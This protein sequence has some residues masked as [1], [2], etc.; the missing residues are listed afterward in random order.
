MSLITSSRPSTDSTP[1]VP[2]PVAP[3]DSRATESPATVRLPAR[4]TRPGP[5]EPPAPPAEVA[6]APRLLLGL[7]VAQVLA[8]ALAA[9]TSALAASFLGVAGTIIGAVVGSLV[10]TVATA[11]YAHSL[12]TAG[13]RLKVVRPGD[14]VVLPTARVASPP[15]VD[16][17]RP[18]PS[19]PGERRGWVRLTTGLVLGIVVALGAVTLVEEVVGHPLSDSASSGT[20]IGEVVTGSGSSGQQAVLPATSATPGAPRGDATTATSSPTGSP[21]GSP[22]DRPSMSPSSSPTTSDPSPTSPDPGATTG[23]SPTGTA[24]PTTAPGSSATG[25]GSATGT[26]GAGGSP[27]R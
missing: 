26:P 6:H 13:V 21:T 27:T 7:S 4:H 19:G 16:P 17:G 2:E 14:T 15:A 20:S 5:A 12:R 22:T 25:T 1:V 23:P 8:S 18:G 3:T 24:S 11:V 9:A 10:A